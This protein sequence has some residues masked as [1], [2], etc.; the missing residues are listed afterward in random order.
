[1]TDENERVDQRYKK[2]YLDAYRAALHDIEQGASTE[3]LRKFV[4]EDLKPWKEDSKIWKG[5]AVSAKY[6]IPH[7]MVCLGVGFAARRLHRR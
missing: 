1:M 6:V 7:E 2:G 3:D 5:E 4:A